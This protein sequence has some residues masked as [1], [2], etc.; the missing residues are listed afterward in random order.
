M[1]KL[2]LK[3]SNSHW[4]EIDDVKFLVDYPTNQQNVELQEIFLD[5]NVSA[6]IR[7][8]RYAKKFLK[9]T[10]KDWQGIDTKCMIINNEL[11]DELW[12][13]LTNDINQTLTIFGKINDELSF[14]ESDK[15]KS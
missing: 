2:A 9:Y 5:T 12:Y 4:L 3:K 1:I 13:A 6:D 10:I 7:N 8:L 15:K 11:E 14:T